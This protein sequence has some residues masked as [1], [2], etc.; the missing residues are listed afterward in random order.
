MA[1][2]W[3]I[4]R[5]RLKVCTPTAKKT[6]DGKRARASR[7]KEQRSSKKPL[8]RRNGRSRSWRNGIKKERLWPPRE[9]ASIECFRKQIVAWARFFRNS[10]GCCTYIQGA[11]RKRTCFVVFISVW[12]RYRGLGRCQLTFHNM[13]LK[14]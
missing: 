6:V 14:L 4:L 7:E 10:S 1:S 3:V 8:R 12:E 13:L 11:T 5:K 2:G 9:N